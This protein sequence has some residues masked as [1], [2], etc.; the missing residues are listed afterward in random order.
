MTTF[1]TSKI[2]DVLERDEKMDKDEK[3]ATT[4]LAPYA[5]K[6]P[7]RELD[8]FPKARIDGSPPL[9]PLSLSLPF[10]SS[11]LSFINHRRVPF[12][13]PTTTTTTHRR[14]EEWP[15]PSTRFAPTAPPLRREHAQIEAEDAQSL[16]LLDHFA[17]APAIAA[18]GAAAEEQ[19][20]T[21]TLI[22]SP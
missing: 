18:V 3:Q 11:S 1:V 16:H 12:P 4:S 10:P 13:S 21:P 20:A 17:A 22:D 5:R 14:D 9:P 8:P 7:A 6:Y 2:R 19:E 15:S